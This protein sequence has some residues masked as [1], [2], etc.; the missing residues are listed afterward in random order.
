MLP[1]R[2]GRFMPFCGGN[3]GECGL[4]VGIPTTFAT[5]VLITS[6]LWYDGGINHIQGGRLPQK[7]RNIAARH[8]CSPRGNVLHRS[9]QPLD[10]VG[11]VLDIARIHPGTVVS[12]SAG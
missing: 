11:G 8:K 3:C 2:H 1:R 7:V 6:S 12:E 10:T 5:K 4:R 9:Y